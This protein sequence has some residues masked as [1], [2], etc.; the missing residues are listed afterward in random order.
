[1]R[2]VGTATP[3]GETARG[4]MGSSEAQDEQK[5]GS[6]HN[7]GTVQAVQRNKADRNGA[8]HDYTAF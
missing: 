5:G 1:M 8:L 2:T 6:S 3:Q 7:A 4:Y